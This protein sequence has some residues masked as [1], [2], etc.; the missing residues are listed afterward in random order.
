MII[1]HHFF[2]KECLIDRALNDY[3]DLKKNLLE[4][5]FTYHLPPIFVNQVHSS[6]VIVIDDESKIP[7]QN[8]R[9]KADALVTNLSNLTI[10]IFTADCTPILFF[11]EKNS[12]IAA[13][14][15]GWQ[16]ALK[17]IMASTIDEMLRIGAKID[18]IKVLIGPTIRQQSYEISEEFYERFLSEDKNNEVF[19]IAANRSE[20]YMFDLPQYVKQ[21]LRV[22]GI[23]DIFDEGIDTYR[24]ERFFSYRRSVHLGEPDC[25]RN[26][27]AIQM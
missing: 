17:N 9:P 22:A 10:G 5:N 19:F 16:G 26:V 4:K 24:S 25:G 21:K 13:A 12:V 6:D 7:P 15:A 20:H 8:N 18:D 1:R 23:K 11:D 27:S 14:H 3:S 2:G